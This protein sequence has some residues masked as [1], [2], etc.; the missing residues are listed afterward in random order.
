[1]APAWSVALT[2]MGILCA[3]GLAMEVVFT[4]AADYPTS[5]DPRLKG[6]TYL[7]MLPIYA[8]VYPFCAVL[9]PR[10]RLYPALVRGLCYVLII[11]AV[12]YGSGWLLRRL[13][14]QCPWEPEYRKAKWHV[15]GLIRLDFAPAWLTAALIFE[16]TYRVLRGLA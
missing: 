6:Y 11:Y 9:V 5:R 16:W 14:G 15:H 2:H 4:A 10:M 7:W 8:M 1:M 13:A 3:L 12:E